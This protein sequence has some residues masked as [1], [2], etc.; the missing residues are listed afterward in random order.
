MKKLA[1]LMS[2]AL[3]SVAPDGP[4]HAQTRVP[5]DMLE[6]KLS[7]APVVKAVVP[8]VVN[9]YA[10]RVVQSQPSPF[11]NDPFFSQFFGDMRS[12]PRLQNS[13][14]SGVILGED[15][16]VV[17]NFHVVGNATDIR[18]V[19]ADKREFDATLLFGDPETD[20]AVLR[21]K[22]APDLPALDFAD[23]DAIE[24]GDLVLAVGNPFGVGQTV[25]SGII[26]ANAR[27]GMVGGRSG[28][29][30]QTDAPIN[31]GNSGGALVDMR[32]QLVGIN[33]AIVTRSGGSNGIGFAIPANLVR[34]YVS[35]AVAGATSLERPWAGITVQPIDGPLADALGLSRPQ[36][37]LVNALH[38]QSPFA[39]AGVTVGDVITS[40]ADL[41]VD[42][43]PE[44][45]FRLLTLGVGAQA[46][47]KYLHKLSEQ[48][49]S[50]TLI[51]APE[52]PPRAPITLTGRTILSGLTAATLNPALITEL[53][54]P[55]DASGV[56][57][58]AL[59][60]TARR[61]QLRP[62]DILRAING[63]EIKR[64]TDLVQFQSTRD[65][66]IEIVFERGGQRG[67][68]RYRN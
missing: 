44:M 11:A 67:V 57:V 63:R 8:S 14:G 30:I 59:D 43:G 56:V 33:S 21:M 28:Y 40:I 54:L 47:V 51:T 18:V 7:Y 5:D 48:E 29:F 62:G 9:I 37:V 17:S 60:G 35:Q 36:G 55:F 6:V 31:P 4:G 2:L 50:V 1:M 49:T 45:L 61:T 24:V 65:R 12:R 25:S 13:L 15:G 46:S 39:S 52:T 34:Q 20:L 26:S 38:P 58:T 16:I 22:N 19:L 66:R 10:K 41:P 53:G 23:S 3:A 42:G 32:G 27:T 64:S 68:L